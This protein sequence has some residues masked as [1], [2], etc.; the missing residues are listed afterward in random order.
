[1]KSFFEFLNDKEIVSDNKFNE[2]YITFSSL[3]KALNSFQMTNID[4]K[5]VMCLIN[6]L[7]DEIYSEEPDE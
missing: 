2:N 5:V 3:R 6:M 1:M 4:D 7:N